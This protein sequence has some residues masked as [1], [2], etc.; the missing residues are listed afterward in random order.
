MSMRIELDKNAAVRPGFTD[1]PK[2]PTFPPPLPRRKGLM[3]WLQRVYKWKRV[4]SPL[5]LKFSW[6]P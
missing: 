3:F 4:A 5:Q 6:N 2:E 1:A